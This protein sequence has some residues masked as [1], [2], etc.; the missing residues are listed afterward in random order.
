MPENSEGL[1]DLDI[2]EDIVRPL[3][4]SHKPRVALIA[5]ENTHNVC[6]GKVLPLQY[7]K[8][9]FTVS[10]DVTFT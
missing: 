5:L 4:A 8:K 6:G 3:H 9:V 7:L 1:F 10:D 2:V